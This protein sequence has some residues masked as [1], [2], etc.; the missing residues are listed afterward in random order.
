[1]KGSNIKETITNCYSKVYNH[2]LS[3][4]IQTSQKYLLVQ[5]GDLLKN[6]NKNKKGLSTG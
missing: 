3:G 5:K 1:M 4:Q 6:K 2:F